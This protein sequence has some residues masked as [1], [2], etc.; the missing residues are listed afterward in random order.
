M[1]SQ[2]ASG[3]VISQLAVPDVR[4]RVSSPTL[5]TAGILQILAGTGAIVKQVLYRAMY[6]LI[7]NWDSG[8]W[9]G[10]VRSKPSFRNV[11]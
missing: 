2:H 10:A 9:T 6:S 7:D 5:I 8:Y 3:I 11:K 1:Q 4:Y